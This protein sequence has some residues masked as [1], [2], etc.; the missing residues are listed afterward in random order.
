MPLDLLQRELHPCRNV[1]EVHGKNFI[2]DSV[3]NRESVIAFRSRPFCDG[4]KRELCCWLAPHIHNRKL[5][6]GSESARE[7]EPSRPLFA[8]RNLRPLTLPGQPVFKVVHHL[9]GLTD[10]AHLPEPLAGRT[11]A[12]DAAAAPF[13][14]SGW[15][16]L[17]DLLEPGYFLPRSVGQA[18]GYFWCFPRYSL[19]PLCNSSG[20]A[21]F[22][23]WPGS[24]ISWRVCPGR[25]INRRT[26][27]GCC[28]LAGAWWPMVAWTSPSGPVRTVI[29]MTGSPSG[30]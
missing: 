5:T 3:Q 26:G 10:K 21:A 6:A 27:C 7:L 4:S 15:F 30:P 24:S 14:C 20:D 29:F 2:E 23:R 25:G 16:A 11:T 22:S 1:S 9:C 12:K 17:A 13:R 28:G 19:R 18:R 8:D